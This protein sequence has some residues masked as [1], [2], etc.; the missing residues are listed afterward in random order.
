[1]ERNERIAALKALKGMVDEALKDEEAGL[2]SQLL[3][4]YEETGVDRLTVRVGNVEV[5][6]ATVTPASESAQIVPG[7]EAEALEFL[8]QLGLTETT[9]VK[10][11]EKQFECIGGLAVHKATGE[12]SEAIEYRPAKAAYVRLTG[13]KPEVVKSAFRAR[14]IEA[15]DYLALV[16]EVT[17]D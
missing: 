8:G 6:K 16:G 2:K 17:N 15:A 5:G 11:W 14:G 1:M 3:E 4:A 7:R 13:F 12:L 10:G 9:P